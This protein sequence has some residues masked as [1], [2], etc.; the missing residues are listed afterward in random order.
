MNPEPGMFYGKPCKLQVIDTVPLPIGP[1]A[2]LLA[3]N[4]ETGL[5]YVG[6]QGDNQ[7][8]RIWR[9]DNVGMKPAPLPMSGK[10]PSGW[11]DMAVLPETSRL[12]VANQQD[13]SLTIFQADG[14]MDTVPSSGLPT[15]VSPWQKDSFVVSSQGSDT[16][17]CMTE[18]SIRPTRLDGVASRV[19]RSGPATDRKLL[20]ALTPASSTGTFDTHVFAGD[21]LKKI[22]EIKGYFGMYGTELF[23]GLAA[24]PYK[25]KGFSILDGKTYKETFRFAE[26]V[27]SVRS[28]LINPILGHV[29]GLTHGNPATL[30]VG[31]P[32][33]GKELQRIT[34]GN[35]AY[36]MVCDEKDG[37]VYIVNYFD[38]T[39][40]VLAGETITPEQ[41]KVLESRT[42]RAIKQ[43]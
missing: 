35:N 9:M 19:I 16:L 38:R 37:R 24:L 12:V 2:G 27:E 21:D 42:G 31:D 32:I 8:G 40:T 20:A 28:V 33:S 15:S 43:R 4:S 39:I 23:S 7:E 17:F 11:H 25:Q 36:A 26:D 18:Q 5:L 1:L 41:H 29:Y 6:S 3:I 22:A 14:H 10:L 30:I 13:G 34:V